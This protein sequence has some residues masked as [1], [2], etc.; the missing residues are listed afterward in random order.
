MHFESGGVADPGE[1]ALLREVL[2]EYCR[3]PRTAERE[4][5]AERILH[6]FFAGTRDR[7][8]LLESAKGNSL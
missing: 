8:A 1:L 6:S 7:D 5:V 4:K 3:E 2:E